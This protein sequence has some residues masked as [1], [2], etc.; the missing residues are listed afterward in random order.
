MTGYHNYECF[1]AVQLTDTESDC[2][3]GWPEIFAELHQVV[4]N[5]GKYIIAFECY[6]GV[7]LE[8]IYRL[9]R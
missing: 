5:S 6:P 2:K 3:L 8:P 9:A 1:P 7:L 4:P